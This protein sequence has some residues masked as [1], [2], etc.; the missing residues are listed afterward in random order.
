MLPGWAVSMR[1][2]KLPAHFFTMGRYFARFS[3]ITQARMAIRAKT[4]GRPD[5]AILILASSIPVKIGTRTTAG[6]P[7]PIP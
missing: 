3:M 6:P 4:M 5:G 7:I 2:I 1:D